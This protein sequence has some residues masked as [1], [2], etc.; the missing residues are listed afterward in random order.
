MDATNRA[1]EAVAVSQG[2]IV[3]VGSNAEIRNLITP[4]TRVQDLGGKVMLP[5]FY[6]PHDHFPGSGTTAL[7]RVD[8]NSPPVGKVETIGD[9]I[10]AL[11][12]IK[13]Y[14][15]YGIFTP[16]QVAAIAALDGPQ[17][18]VREAAAV[19]QARRDALVGGLNRIG[20]PVKPCRASMFLWTPIPEPYR[21]MGS[22][23]F[24]MKLLREAEV[25][26]S[27]GRAFGDLGE[28]Y[29]RISL[30]ENEHRINQAIRNIKKCLF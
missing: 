25:V 7:Y 30:V 9:L 22:M 14:T 11:A 20:W 6:A 23:E 1:A 19:Y 28:G 26:V 17:D 21:A 18:C 24:S 13:G 15:D 12:K 10:E 5:G 3:A 29:I 16:I 4:N 2:K 8:L 27:P